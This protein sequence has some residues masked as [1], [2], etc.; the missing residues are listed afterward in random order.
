[1]LLAALRE[2]KT[3]CLCNKCGRSSGMDIELGRANMLQCCDM[4]SA[5]FG[6]DYFVDHE[7]TRGVLMA[8]ECSCTA[9]CGLLPSP[10][11]CAAAL[12]QHSC[13]WPDQHG[14]RC[15]NFF[16]IWTTART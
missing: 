16:R 10:A 12:V 5:M 8:E 15:Q 9:V 1:M 14:A 7:V 3:K 13:V 6:V 11:V 2:H 4:Q